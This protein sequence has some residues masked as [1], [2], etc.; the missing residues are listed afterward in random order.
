MENRNNLLLILLIAV[1]IL[2]SWG[3]TENFNRYNAPILETKSCKEDS[4]QNVINQ[5]KIDIENEEDGWDEKEKRYESILFEY[6]YG[7]E[8]LKHYHNEAYREF[9]RII[10]H[11]EYYTKENERENKQRLKTTSKW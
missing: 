3:L 2:L 6:D 10:S 11:K 9:H 4:L 1:V 5:M 7:M 8:H